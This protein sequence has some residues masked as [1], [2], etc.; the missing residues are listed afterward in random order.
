MLRPRRIALFALLAVALYLALTWVH[1]YV[2]RGYAALFRTGADIAFTR[3][4]FWGDGHVRFLDLH[5]RSG[6]ADLNAATGL[7]I[8]RDYPLRPPTAHMDTRVVVM[9]RKVRTPFGLLRMSSQLVGYEPTIVII[10]LIL[11]TPFPTWSR[12]GWALLVGFLLVHGYIVLRLTLF[13]LVR[14]YAIPKAYALFHPS[15][16]WFGMVKRAQEVVHE[17]PTASWVFPVLI[18]FV[19][20]LLMGAFSAFRGTYVPEGSYQA[21]A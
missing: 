13:L 4:W 21:E 9:N 19:V 12:R 7:Q 6:H 11:A 14:A 2:E 17:N 5:S 18:W 15:D 16:F 3:F 10:A 20:A 1:P 8:P